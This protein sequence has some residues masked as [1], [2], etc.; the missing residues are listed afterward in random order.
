[1]TSE[2]PLKFLVEKRGYTLKEGSYRDGSENEN[3]GEG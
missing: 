2:K 3:E 1:M